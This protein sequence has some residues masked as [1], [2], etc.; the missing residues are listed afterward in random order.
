MCGYGSKCSTSGCHDVCIL[1]ILITICLIELA[2]YVIVYVY[3]SLNRVLVRE[4]LVPYPLFRCMI[5]QLL[6]FNHASQTGDANYH[7]LS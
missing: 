7:V 4:G 2:V 5:H 3:V 1:A 6:R